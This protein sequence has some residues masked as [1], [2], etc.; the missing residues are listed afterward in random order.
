[1]R[2]MTALLIPMLAFTACAAP[3]VPSAPRLDPTVVSV[4][5]T[6]GPAGSL[7]PPRE[8]LPAANIRDSLLAVSW[9][10]ISEGNLLFPVDPASGTALPGFPPVAIGQGFFHAFSPERR[11]LAVVSFPNDHGTNGSLLLID[12][13]GWKTRRFE[14]KLNGWVRAILFSP[15][16][17]RLVIAHGDPV[18]RLSA[19]DLEQEAITAQVETDA[20]VTKMKFTAGGDAL[21]VYGPMIKNRLTANEM[22]G[23][24]PQILLLDAVD[25][26]TRWSAELNEVHD[27]IYPKDENITAAHILE[28]GQAVYISPA[29]AFA[30]DRDSLYIVQAD[31]NRLT[32][33]E[34]SSQRIKTVEVQPELGWLERLLSATAGVAS[35]KVGD[36]TS[37]QAAIS[38]DGQRL[39][40]IGSSHVMIE[41]QQGN[42]QTEQNLLGLEVIR[43]SNG[44]RIKRMETDAIELSLAPDGRYLYLK[45]WAGDVPSTE[46]FD[47][48]TW[49]LIARKSGLYATP[50]SLSDG[51]FLLVSSYPAAK[52]S[53]HMSV[54]EPDSLRLLADWTEPGYTYWLTTP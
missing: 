9:K 31:S 26:S 21:M 32:T 19:F 14:L 53:Q 51:K 50:A 18:Y 38:P 24:P 8:L 6:A 25:L 10:G 29:L 40:V 45:S 2:I 30:P 27:G 41:D 16:E 3:A 42:W 20:F 47:T 54:L 36:A 13:P 48:S 35:A 23:G 28:P 12:L 11:T 44:S 15:D 4:E 17:K 34:F 46:I 37:K 52:S 5:P 33:V 39:Y 7:S 43:T 22:S 49:Q 1:M